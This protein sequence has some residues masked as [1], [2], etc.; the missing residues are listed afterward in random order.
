MSVR[1]PTAGTWSSSQ[2]RPDNEFETH[3]FHKGKL[4]NYAGGMISFAETRAQRMASGDPRLSLEERYETHAGYVEAVKVAAA[5]AV[6]EKFLVQEDADALVAEAAASDV[7]R[8]V[9]TTASNT[10]Q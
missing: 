1:S 5:K 10:G 3:R 4:C 6:A 7:L 2:W 8:P 9:Q